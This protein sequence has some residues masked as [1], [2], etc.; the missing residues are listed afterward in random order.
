[1]MRR[2]VLLVASMCAAALPSSAPADIA[3]Y[4][5][6]KGEQKF[7]RAS[8]HVENNAAVPLEI[9]VIWELTAGFT[10]DLLPR[11]TIEPL[12][13]QSFLYAVSVGRNIINLRIVVDGNIHQVTQD[14]FVNNEL[15]Q[16]CR[17]TY[18][19]IVTNRTFPGA[20]I[21]TATP[22]GCFA[23][24]RGA[25]SRGLPARDLNGLEWNSAAMT[26]EACVARCAQG[27]FAFA[28]L[29]FRSWCFCGNA[30]NRHPGGIA[31]CNMPCAGNPQQNCGGEWANSIYRLR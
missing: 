16:T 2:F 20:L 26:V 4:L 22:L 28:G 9:S 3:C 23:D 27:G 29:Q 5:D 17:R 13:G 18:R 7:P 6:P 24:N 12:K 19:V 15:D 11:R 25:A 1:M 31:I 14:L 10:V 8:L 30:Y 21:P